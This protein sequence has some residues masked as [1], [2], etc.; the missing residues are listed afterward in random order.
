MSFGEPICFCAIGSLAETD[1]AGSAQQYCLRESKLSLD[2]IV[3]SSI[4]AP[5][6]G[7]LINEGSWFVH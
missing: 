2:I 1:T 4:L 6:F 5:Y 7:I 3:I